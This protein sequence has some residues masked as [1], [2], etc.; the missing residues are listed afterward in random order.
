MCYNT[1]YSQRCSIRN[2]YSWLIEY[3][4]C[5]VV[6]VS[7]SSLG[8]KIHYATELYGIGVK[9]LEKCARLFAQNFF[10]INKTTTNKRKNQ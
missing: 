5:C 2:R 6:V 8:P 7:F 3:G 9:F 4:C 10:L 1:H